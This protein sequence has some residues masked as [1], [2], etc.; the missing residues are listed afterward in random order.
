[1]SRDWITSPSPR[2]PI[3]FR[4]PHTERPWWSEVTESAFPDYPGPG[5]NTL[6]DMPT[7]T[8]LC[9]CGCGCTNTARN[10]LYCGNCQ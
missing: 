10:G 7:S 9:R 1:M 5:E 8:L 4:D 2:E 3:P 6:P